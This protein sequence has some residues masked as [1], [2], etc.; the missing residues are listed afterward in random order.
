MLKVP[1]SI[2]ASFISQGNKFGT[3]RPLPGG[4]CLTEQSGGLV[5]KR[6][7]EPDGHSG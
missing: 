3:A 1:K 6:D 7:R 4:G 2:V 5:R